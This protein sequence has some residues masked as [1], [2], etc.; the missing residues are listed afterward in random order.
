[1]V[2]SRRKRGLF[3]FME[4][5]V[6]TGR[7]WRSMAF[8]R[9]VNSE[10]TCVGVEDI[11]SSSP[12]SRFL[13]VPSKVRRILVF[14]TSSSRRACSAADR[15]LSARLGTFKMAGSPPP[16]LNSPVEHL[17]SSPLALACSDHVRIARAARTSADL[18]QISTIF[19]SLWFHASSALSVSA[20]GQNER[21]R[22]ERVRYSCP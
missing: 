4:Y 9:K 18:G 7:R 17:S 11:A 10:W 1:M 12:D 8:Q 22:G 2:F 16:V 6:I 20:G 14:S 15:R 3:A 19:A 21:F 5:C 13:C